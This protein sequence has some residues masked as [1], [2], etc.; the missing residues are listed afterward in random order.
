MR[1][2]GG[3]ARGRPAQ[4][5]GGRRYWKYSQWLRGERDR[6]RAEEDKAHA[7][8]VGRRRAE[9]AAEDAKRHPHEKGI[10][11][12]NV[13]LNY[14]RR[15][16]PADAPPAKSPSEVAAAAVCARTGGWGGGGKP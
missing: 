8:E 13:L 4:P 15:V 11:Q 14:L 6:Q 9:K 10:A 2:C 16:R 3:A 5:C 1:A 12:C 7:A